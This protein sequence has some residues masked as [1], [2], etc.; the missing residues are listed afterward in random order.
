[1]YLKNLIWLFCLKRAK[2]TF[3]DLVLDK[4]CNVLRRAWASAEESNDEICSVMQTLSFRYS[5][6]AL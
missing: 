2:K 1:M 5:V 6:F 3:K 4:L